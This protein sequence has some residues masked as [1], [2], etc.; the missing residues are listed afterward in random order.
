[1]FYLGYKQVILPQNNVMHWNKYNI[2]F[3]TK[4]TLKKRYNFY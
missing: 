1:M 2:I 4:K 3:W